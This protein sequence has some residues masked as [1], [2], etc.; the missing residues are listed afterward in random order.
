MNFK[1]YDMN[2]ECS[3]EFEAENLEDKKLLQSM[4]LKLI[5]NKTEVFEHLKELEEYVE[6]DKYGWTFTRNPPCHVYSCA[7]C[8]YRKGYC[9]MYES[10]KRME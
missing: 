10:E 4:Y 1:Y 5:R 7:N 8:P 6:E 2:G 3:I 9:C